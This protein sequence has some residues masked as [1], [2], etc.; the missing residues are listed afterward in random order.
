MSYH[1]NNTC[2]KIKTFMRENP[3]TLFIA[4]NWNFESWGNNLLLFLLIGQSDCGILKNVFLLVR[5]SGETKIK[6]TS[7]SRLYN[8]GAGRAKFKSTARNFLFTRSLNYVLKEVSYSFLNRIYS[9]SYIF[10]EQALFLLV[11]TYIFLITTHLICT[12]SSK[13]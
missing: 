7:W 4:I 1:K 9:S 10:T 2:S 11:L 3:F 12:N 13:L 5:E 8:W 6:V